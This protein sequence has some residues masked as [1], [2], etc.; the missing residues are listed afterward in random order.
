MKRIEYRTEDKSGWGE[1]PWQQEPDKIQWLDPETMLPCLIVRGPVGSWCGYV[2]VTK[3]HPLYGVSYSQCPQACGEDWCDHRPESTLNAHGGIT[4]AGLCAK[5]TREEWK[6]WQKSLDEHRRVAKQYPK[7][8]SAKFLREWETPLKSY[9]QWVARREATS[10]CHVPEDS[11][12]DKVWWFGFDCAHAGDWSPG[13]KEH[14]SEDYLKACGPGT[15]TGWGGVT[16]YRNIEY[17][18]KQCEQLAQ[19]LKTIHIKAS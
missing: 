9:A 10:I 3:N 2:G 18:T 11:E 14:V 5:S 1:G 17:V 7:G 13:M 12:P 6:Q 19:Q 15:P 4:F 8:D 16:E